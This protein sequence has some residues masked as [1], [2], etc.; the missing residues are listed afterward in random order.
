MDLA[1]GSRLGPYEIIAAVGA[2]GMGE[3]YRARDTRLDRCVAIKILPSHLSCSPELKGRFERE[4]RT[5]SSVTHPNI[6]HLYDVG[7]Q[8]GIH[9]LVMELLEGETLSHRLQKG[10]LPLGDLLKIA[11][12]ITD[13]LTKAHRLGLVHRDLKPSNIMLTKTGA[14]LM[15]FG[16]AKSAAADPFAGGAAPPAGE[17]LTTLQSPVSPLTSA[18]AIVGTLQYMSPEQIE[19]KEADVRS[20]IFALGAVLYEMVT[21]R[22][23]FEG[24]SRVSVASAILEKDPAPVTTLQPATPAA[25]AYLIGTCLAKDP[26]ERF[27]TAHDVALQLRW[28]SQP[29]GTDSFPTDRRAAPRWRLFAISF[30]VALV[31]ALAALLAKVSITPSARD[32]GIVRFSIP[33][34]AKQE[35]AAD[36]TQSVAISPDGKR[37]AYVAAESGVSHLY[38][39]RLDQVEPIAIPDS[40]GA[41][42][43]FF[44]PNGDWVVFLSG[45]KLKKAPS[46]G[47]VPVALGEV[48]AIFGG[49][50]TPRDVIVVSIP[51]EGMATMPA[52][53]GVMRKVP[54]ADNKL[55]YP[56]GMTWLAG[57]DWVTFT[58]YLQPRRS[59]MAIKLDSGE[60]RTLL[61]NASSSSYAAGH[62]LFYQGG[63]LWA[64]SFDQ[65]KLQ[66]LGTP[67]Q[68]VNGVN[69]TNYIP[70]VSVS[71]TGVLAYAPGPFGNAFR[72]LL[73]VNR[74]GVEQK[75]DLPPKDYIDPAFSLDGKRI[76]LV[77]RSLQQLLVLDRDRGTIANLA[78]GFLNY[79][80][81]WT[82]D[83]KNL[84][85]D[86][87]DGA[88]QH[89]IYRVA[90]D[91]SSQ[92]EL[93]R[94]IPQ[95]SHVTSIAGDYAAVQV[96][97]PVN[98]ID[99]W[100]LSMR[101]PFELRPFKRTPAVE[102]Q[103]S[104][105]PDGRWMAYASSESGRS[106]IY[107]E[108]VPGPGGLRQISADG[109]DQPR[110]VRN[111]REIVYRSG[112]KVISVP[113]QLS[114]QFQPG[115]PVELFDRKFDPGAAVAGYDVSPDG[116]TFVMTRS[117]RDNPTEIR[118]VL[119]WPSDKQAQH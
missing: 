56:Q 61:D 38:V 89:G 113:V 85:I 103:G 44:S 95:T 94:A 100:L 117:E 98:A 102:R 81:T 65:D 54:V 97:D 110:W 80:P 109:G 67:T 118:L 111:G 69:E 50:W 105:S 11:V 4:A 35:L 33:L 87:F 5:L 49:V 75:L 37:L 20:D 55:I 74:K 28:L 71:R 19:G 29:G 14:K 91:G 3:V 73:L 64:V 22:R 34:P 62:L 93:L 63:A 43:P 47:G 41:T 9:F 77:I 6:C 23:A 30:A 12:E 78:S 88:R 82:P 26:D 76:A 106:E 108:P 119:G 25:L 24:K 36:V 83:G 10:P 72:N 86:A 99:L 17:T 32:Y 27:Q 68:V 116:Q 48:H 79:A 115:K 53:G 45:G 39:R 18:G 70:Q 1:A 101:P 16:L 96:T 92:P 40:E 60:V 31:L 52:G 58:D 7:S 107:V 84:L 13:A 112:T 114:P 46:D 59:I 57:G 15:D 51:N 42:F 90:A 21:G 104:L 66:V 8:S 2:G